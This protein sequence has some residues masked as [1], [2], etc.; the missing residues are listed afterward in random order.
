MKTRDI[1]H[2]MRKAIAALET[3]DVEQ[4]VG[5]GVPEIL[6]FYF[7]MV[8]IA[9]VREDRSRTLYDPDS[10]GRW[11]YITP[12][13]VQSSETPESTR[14][15]AYPLIGNLVDLVAW[16]EKT[17]TQWRLRV[18]SASWLG[19]I[20]PQYFESDPV[21]IWRSPL[22]WLRARCQGLV[23]LSPERAERYSLLAGCSAGLVAEDEEHAA[24]LRDI[25]ERP[26]PAPRVSCQGITCR[27]A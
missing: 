2:E 24:A 10:S 9:R 26:W 7:Q 15:D 19:C 11:A 3:R 22:N 4:L 27:A 25:L 18:G 5:L 14:P 13:C 8:G 1:A 20:E 23:I 6:I 16:D 12:V 21:T 17:P